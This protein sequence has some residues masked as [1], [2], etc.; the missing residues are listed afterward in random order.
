HVSTE[1][2]VT[3][4]NC[5]VTENGLSS[6]CVMK[7]DRRLRIAWRAWL[8]ERGTM[9]MLERPSEAEIA[10]RFRKYFKWRFQEALEVLDSGECSALA[11]VLT[12]MY[13]LVI[14]EDELEGWRPPALEE[15]LSR[16]GKPLSSH[17]GGKL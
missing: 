4:G 3:T 2:A 6:S 14:G 10:E 12:E 15:T 11:E 17:D 9:Q 1:L 16:I 8:A 5:G 13:A 7:V